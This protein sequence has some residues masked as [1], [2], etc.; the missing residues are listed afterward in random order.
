[1]RVSEKNSDGGKYNLLLCLSTALI[2][3]HSRQDF[4][5]FVRYKV[6]LRSEKYFWLFYA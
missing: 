4:L 6:D 3:M 1:M 5:N 2:M